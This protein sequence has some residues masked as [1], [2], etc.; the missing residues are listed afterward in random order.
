MPAFVLH[1]EIRSSLFGAKYELGELVVSENQFGA[2]NEI[3]RVLALIDAHLL[4][5]TPTFSPQRHR[6]YDRPADR[7]KMYRV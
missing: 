3:L 2:I 5:E 1:E 7:V 6:R 4:S